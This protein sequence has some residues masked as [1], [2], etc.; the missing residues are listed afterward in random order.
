MLTL[1]HAPDE[2]AGLDN[3]LADN[4]LLISEEMRMTIVAQVVG[5]GFEVGGGTGSD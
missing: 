3:V 1:K 5:K 2:D 4:E